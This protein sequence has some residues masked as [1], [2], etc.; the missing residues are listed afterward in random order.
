MID[1]NHELIE[2]MTNERKNAPPVSVHLRDANGKIICES[3]RQEVER[4]RADGV[5]QLNGV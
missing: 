1:R 2:I 3:K 4:A 5:K